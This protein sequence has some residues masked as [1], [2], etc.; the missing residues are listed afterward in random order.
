MAM[1]PHAG[2]SSG[3]SL[4]SLENT[5][6]DPDPAKHVPHFKRL[7]LCTCLRA[8]LARGLSAYAWGDIP[9]T[10]RRVHGAVLYSGD[11][12]QETILVH[13]PPGQAAKPICFPQLRG[14]C[15]DKHVNALLNRDGISMCV[16]AFQE[17]GLYLGVQVWL[18]V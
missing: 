15:K 14:D 11:T 10:E 17:R 8:L 18:G 4:C 5:D 12:L 3:E 7:H 9:E 13:R 6:L 16:S 2:P 1:S